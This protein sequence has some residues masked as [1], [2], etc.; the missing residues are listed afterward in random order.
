MA[1]P[2]IMQLKC[3]AGCFIIKNYTIF[4]KQSFLNR[5]Y[6]LNLAPYLTGSELRY[7]NINHQ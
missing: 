2:C 6:N 1:G 3:M 5:P 7:T 4:I